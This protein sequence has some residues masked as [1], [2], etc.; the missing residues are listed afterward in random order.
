LRERERAKKKKKAMIT[1]KVKLW[2]MM[3]YIT[4]KTFWLWNK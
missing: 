3:I 2:T 4:R 1:D